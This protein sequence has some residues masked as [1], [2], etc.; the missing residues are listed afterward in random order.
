MGLEK[1]R[2][3]RDPRRT[4]E[5]G[6][7]KSKRR[8]GPLIFVVQ[9]HKA[10]HLH[11]DFRLEMRGTLKS[12]AVPKGPSM[13]PVD[14]R[15]AMMVEDHPYDYK[16]FAGVIPEGNYGAGIV[17][18]W[19]SG[20]YAPLDLPEGKDPE[21]FLMHML[22]SGSLKIVLKGRKLKGEFALVRMKG[23]EKSWLLIKHR[24]KHAVDSYNSEEQTPKNSPINKALASA[25]KTPKAKKSA[26]RSKVVKA[27][28]PSA[29]AEPVQRERFSERRMGSAHKVRD[30]IKPM[31]ASPDVKPFDDPDW[32]FEIKWDGYRAIAETGGR[33]LRL[34][35]RN[36]LSFLD[37][38]ADVATALR[39][40]RRRA[41][42]DGEVVALD[43]EGHPDFQLLQHASQEPATNVVYYVFDLLRLDGKDLTEL[44]L[45][46]RKK[47]LRTL[48]KDGAHMRYCDHVHE[49]GTEF[50]AAAVAQDLEGIIG[51]RAASPYTQGVRSKSW[52]KIK[53]HHTQEVV[54][55][56][57][58]APRNSREHFGALLLGVY[59]KNKLV[60][61]GHTGTGFDE[62]TLDELIATMKPLVAKASPFGGKVDANMPP[63]WVKPQLVCNVKFTEWTRDG[64]MRHPVFLG[65]RTDKRATDVTKEPVAMKSTKSQAAKAAPRPTVT[66]TKKR[67]RRGTGRAP[68]E[69]RANEREVKV[70]RN[71][72][73][74]T[75]LNKPYW[76]K[77]G[78][79]KGDVI[80]YYERMH[81]V[82]LPH[83]KDRPQSLFRTP[84]GIAAPG[85]FQKD[86]GGTA[87]P[88][89]PSVKIPSDSRGG[90]TIDYLLCNDLG[91]LL[92]IANLGCIEINPWS[93]RKQHLLKPDHLVL[94]LDPSAKNTFDQVVEAALAVKVVLDRIGAKGYCKTS[95]SSG[96]HIYIPTGGAY[97]Y[98]QLAPIAK[99]I[100][101]VVQNLLP[102]STTLERSLAKR[103]PKKIYLDHL[104]N[105]KGQTIASVYSIRP[106][107]GAT[108]STPL[109]WSEVR[110]G[111]DPKAFTMRT[112]PER[113][114]KLGDL[115]KPML[116]K[117]GF[118]LR[119]VTAALSG[120][121]E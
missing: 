36:G 105:R 28:A 98:T 65:L 103:D 53:H 17:E 39:K 64:Q 33:D 59:E 14:K 93:S 62:L 54:I 29:I 75:N 120:L 8:D 89:V 92:Y 110:I 30:P 35:S 52:V 113:T 91:T 94:D 12:W 61:T 47:L 41:V 60:Y 63:V 88:W 96:L 32:L 20:T 22:H 115:F 38:Y 108:V 116:G 66:S 18:I 74:L 114:E 9:R 6:G 31:L 79:T 95:G 43:A 86:A 7:A 24:D 69:A 101:V 112:V 4:P 111:L 102:G 67:A 42:L 46:Q 76:P 117:S 106:K 58:T 97:T 107:P 100:M 1:Y 2:A 81:T 16:D 85:F 37:A 21:T 109:K 87:P 50:F 15:L 26:G 82:I 48:I 68:K 40:F 90:G 45:V 80:D 73:H 121:Q 84:N 19:D 56:G 13:A 70:G 72:V 77:E 5:P 55:G 78:I 57:Y 23:Q 10:S 51:K 99:S 34:Y 118:D 83:L 27:L 3:K 104:Q 44:P 49:R 11:Y 119:K 25:G 71:M